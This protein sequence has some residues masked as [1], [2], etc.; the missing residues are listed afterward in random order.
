MSHKYENALSNGL[1]NIYNIMFSDSQPEETF[2]NNPMQPSD[3]GKSVA[4]ETTYL[5]P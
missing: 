2:Y 4:A 1:F 5:G 3:I